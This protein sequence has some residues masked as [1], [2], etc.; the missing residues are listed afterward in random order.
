MPRERADRDR[1]GTGEQAL[2]QP[3]QAGRAPTN[4][5]SSTA[6][7]MPTQRAGHTQPCQP[8]ARR[9]AEASTNA[10][11]TNSRMPAV[12]SV[13]SCRPPRFAV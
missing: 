6:K 9:I 13:A 5:T 8:G 2:E 10:A 12:L 11:A 4:A 7:M 1:S 3:A